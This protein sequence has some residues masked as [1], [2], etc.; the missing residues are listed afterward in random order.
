[1]RSGP[2]LASVANLHQLLT[3]FE[4]SFLSKSLS[5]P[6]KFPI[7][8]ASRFCAGISAGTANVSN[9]GTISGGV[10]GF[11]IFASATANVSSS[12]TI[13]AGFAITKR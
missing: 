5:L 10:N 9:S 4:S 12:G 8:A 6:S 3:R 7:T 13:S 2:R 1:M 11:G